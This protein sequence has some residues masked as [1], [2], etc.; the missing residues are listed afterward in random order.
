MISDPTSQWGT[1]VESVSV[2]NASWEFFYRP[3]WLKDG[4]EDSLSIIR[5]YGVSV[6]A[7]IVVGV[8]RI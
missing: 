2:P 1:R 3:C 6:L 7:E 8:E 4:S 5:V